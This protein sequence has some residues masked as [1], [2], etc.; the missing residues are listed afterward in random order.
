MGCYSI[1]I[2]EFHHIS[3]RNHHGPCK[4]QGNHRLSAIDECQVTPKLLRSYQLL[5][6]VCPTTRNHHRT[7]A[8]LT[9]EGHNILLVYEL[10]REFSTNQMN[11]SRRSPI[12]IFGFQ[13]DILPTN[14][15]V[16][17]KNWCHFAA[18]GPLI[19]LATYHLH[20]SCSYKS[21]AEVL[22]YR[23]GFLG[24][25]LGLPNISPIFAWEHNSGR[26]EPSTFS[27]I[28]TQGSSVGS[29]I[30]HGVIITRVQIHHHLQT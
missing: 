9:E 5:S 26:I 27:L 18:I 25:G 24:S 6:Q 11:N 3:H 10:H 28:D 15:R 16:K 29:S 22:N 17:Y 14:G 30:T 23:K 13:Q 8:P 1:K 20:Q 19:Q 7:V 12:S 21:R 2:L 4:D